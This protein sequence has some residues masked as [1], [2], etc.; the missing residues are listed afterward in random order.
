M[1]GEMQ[2]RCQGQI[3]SDGSSLIPDDSAKDLRWT[4]G[5]EQ[6]LMMISDGCGCHGFHSHR[7]VLVYAGNK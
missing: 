1:S 6:M 7:E 3:N 2:M 4:T 5:Q